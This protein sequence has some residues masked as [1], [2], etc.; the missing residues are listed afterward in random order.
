MKK[1]IYIVL[2]APILLFSLC[3]QANT[4]TKTCSGQ[5]RYCD[6]LGICTNEHYYLYSYQNVILNQDGTFKRHRYRMR[7]RSIL[8]DASDYTPRE[9]AVGE[10]VVYDG[11]VFSLAIPWVAGLPLYYFQPN[12]GVDEWQELCL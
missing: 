7:T 9:T 2:S 3:S 8:G 1:F 6:S 5:I 11:P 4:V 10:Y 12:F